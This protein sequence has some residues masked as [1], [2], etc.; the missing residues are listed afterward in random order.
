M[1][2]YSSCLFDP[3]RGISSLCVQN[4]VPL[5]TR[6]PCL[7]KMLIDFQYSFSEDSAE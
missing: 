6:V 4:N 1:S 2:I 5:Y 7:C 3:L